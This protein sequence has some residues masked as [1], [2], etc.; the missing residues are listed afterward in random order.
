MR[1]FPLVNWTELDVWDYIAVEKIPVVVLYFA[2]PWPV[3][4]SV[5]HGRRWHAAIA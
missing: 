2:K 5:D 4:R 3:V 1:V